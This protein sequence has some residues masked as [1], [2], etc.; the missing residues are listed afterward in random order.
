MVSATGHISDN[1]V[2]DGQN[3]PVF[4]L[5]DEDGHSPGHQL[6]VVLYPLC[7]GD[8]F[9][10]R[11]VSCSDQSQWS[12]AAPAQGP[13]PNLASWGLR[14]APL[15][16][17]AAFSSLRHSPVSGHEI[18]VVG[19]NQLFSNLFLMNQET[20]KDIVYDKD[21]ILCVSTFRLGCNAPCTSHHGCRLQRWK[22]LVQSN[23]LCLTWGPQRAPGQGQKWTE[24]FNTTP[25]LRFCALLVTT[26]YC[27]W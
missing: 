17:K 9:P 22:L 27:G 6:T 4:R 15:L 7:P 1:H 21:I 5:L 18:N 20:P 24:K 14:R 26:M 25:D 23:G 11:V 16:T 19:G 13:C 12:A 3:L 2:G 8:E 10:I